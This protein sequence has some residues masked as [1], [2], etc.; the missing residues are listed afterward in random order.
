ML[1]AARGRSNGSPTTPAALTSTKVASPKQPLAQFS[2]AREI[3]APR[4]MA[5]S[6]SDSW[7]RAGLISQ[8]SN[9]QVGDAGRAH[10]AEP[11]QLLPFNVIKE[12]HAAAERLALANRFECS[13][14]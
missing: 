14:S 11:G 9:E 7:C 10:V 3:R 2:V 6:L 13:C 5:Y 12:Q 8:Q 4:S 1:P